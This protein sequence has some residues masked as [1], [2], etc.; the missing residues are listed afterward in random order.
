MIRKFNNTVSEK[1]ASACILKGTTKAASFC[2][3]FGSLIASC[4][5][6]IDKNFSL[7]N[8]ETGAYFGY[9]VGCAI[10]VRDEILCILQAVREKSPQKN[11]AIDNFAAILTACFFAYISTMF[12]VL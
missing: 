10:F 9:L 4:V 5:F 2:I 7:G 1:D 3:L 12:M 8:L 6:L 11:P